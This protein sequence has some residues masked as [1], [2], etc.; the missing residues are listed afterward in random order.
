MYLLIRWLWY[1]FY[2]WYSLEIEFIILFT[3]FLM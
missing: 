3:Y 2:S 1:M